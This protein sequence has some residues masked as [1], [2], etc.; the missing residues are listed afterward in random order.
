MPGAEP[1]L[2]GLG[3]EGVGEIG[4]VE[5]RAREPGGR[6][7]RLGGAEA[8]RVVVDEAEEGRRVA[9]AE[10]AEEGALGDDAAEGGAGGGDAGERIRG[11]QAEEDLLQDLVQEVR[12]R[13]DHGRRCGE[14]GD[15]WLGFGRS[16]HQVE[17]GAQLEKRKKK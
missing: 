9:L 2:L 10:A 4:G 15:R 8:A 1:P 11:G 12:R 17:N 7:G 13:R 14:E 5:E 6:V 3:D 16:W